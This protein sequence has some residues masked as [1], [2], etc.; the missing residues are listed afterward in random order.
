MWPNPQKTAD[1]VTYPEEILN[2]KLHF[3]RCA[4][5]KICHGYLTFMKFERHALPKADLKNLKKYIDYMTHSLSSADISIL[6]E[7]S[8]FWKYKEIQ[9]I[10]L[11]AVKKRN[12]T[13]ANSSYCIANNLRK[14][15]NISNFTSRLWWYGK[16]FWQKFCLKLKKCMQWRK[17][18]G[19]ISPT[20]NYLLRSISK[21]L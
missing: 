8:N 2:G 4:L 20:S 13:K 16:T 5:P 3:L 14:D 7:I 15:Y 17:Q 18:T 6:W 10:K 21:L 11:A 9:I 1:L 19:I 12:G